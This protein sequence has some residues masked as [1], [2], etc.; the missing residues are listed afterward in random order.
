MQHEAEIAQL[1]LLEKLYRFERDTILL[2]R[3][4]MFVIAI[5]LAVVNSPIA[6]FSDQST[7]LLIMFFAY[8]LICS[9]MLLRIPDF[10]PYIRLYA[11]ITFA[12][13]LL[14]MA[15]LVYTTEGINSNYHIMFFLIILHGTGLFE[16]PLHTLIVYIGSVLLYVVIALISS[17]PTL[18]HSVSITRFL[19]TLSQIWG[20]VLLS[21]VL[22]KNLSD[23]N[24]ELVVSL[25]RLRLQG[26]YNLGLLSSMSDG[27]VSTNGEGEVVFLNESACRILGVSDSEVRGKD[28]YIAFPALSR[29]IEIART[30]REIFTNHRVEIRRGDGGK[31][32]LIAAARII[33]GGNVVPGGAPGVVCVFKDIS[34][35]RELEEGLIRTEKLATVGE[36]AAGLAHEI[37]NPLGIIKSSAKYLQKTE[38][39]D[40]DL[41]EDLE[42]IES[43]ATR[44]QNIVQQLLKLA[45]PGE[46]VDVPLEINTVVSQSANL[47]QL[48]SESEEIE[49]V[50]T[51]PSYPIVISGDEKQL[52]SVVTNIMLNASEALDGEG[53]IELE[54]NERHE[55]EGSWAV[56]RI[57][58]NGCGIAHKDVA[59]IF[60]PFFTRKDRGTGLGLSITLKVV[61]RMGGKVEVESEVDKGTTFT[62]LFPLIKG[63]RMPIKKGGSLSPTI[64]KEHDT[65]G[66]E[67]HD[68]VKD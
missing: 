1:T 60:D 59:R 19:V 38:S 45:S 9:Y 66:D 11:A 16:K 20:V 6:I 42:I 17:P 30:R 14:F 64:V 55:E 52:A 3:W 25:R 67:Y 5:L 44:C 47:I 56:I 46:F 37:G 68:T 10:I 41:R 29:I 36:I 34:E 26:Q 4:V 27:V 21:W 39:I 32:D 63:A 51:I 50:I 15:W 18:L 2:I 31:V 7:I 57:T 35:I 58:D 40:S 53:R 48:R 24:E 13:D 12:L 54:L 62:L 33:E 43:E 49:V 8:V 61:E 23:Q 65:S 22:M 28:V